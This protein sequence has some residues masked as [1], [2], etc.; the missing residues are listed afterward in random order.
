MSWKNWAAAAVLAS[1]L[2][3][4]TAAKPA[5]LPIDQ[6]IN[7][8][9]HGDEIP[10]APPPAAPMAQPPNAVAAPAA[11]DSFQRA[12]RLRLEGHL[13]EARRGYEETHIIAPTSRVGKQAI[14]RLR[15]LER[16]GNDFAEEQEPPLGRQSLRVNGEPRGE[17]NRWKPT[18]QEFLEMLRQTQPLG[19]APTRKG[20]Y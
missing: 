7:Y 6:R 17:T 19:S 8:A 3:A 12:E 18:M 5:D 10:A 16:P 15:D 13:R 11:V 2:P 20:P 9:G 1:Q 4:V 14:Q